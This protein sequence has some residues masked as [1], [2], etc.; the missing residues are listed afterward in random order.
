ME[1]A[2][3][4][5]SV[6]VF[7]SLYVRSTKEKNAFCLLGLKN[8]VSCVSKQKHI[9]IQYTAVVHLGVILLINQLL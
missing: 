3:V 9:Y 4:T 5:C 6:I 1:I 7:L 8:C 2:V